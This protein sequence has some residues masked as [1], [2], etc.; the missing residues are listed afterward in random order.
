MVTGRMCF[1]EGSVERGDCSVIQV[2]SY[3]IVLRR[4]KEVG[5]IAHARARQRKRMR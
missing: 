3:M 2:E 1:T 4:T 5:Q